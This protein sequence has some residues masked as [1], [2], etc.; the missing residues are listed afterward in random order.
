[1][2]LPL[3]SLVDATQDT[4]AHTRYN[5][6]EQQIRPWNVSDNTV[7]EVLHSLR[8]ED[9]VPPAHYQK[10]FMD[11]EIP[12]RDDAF[13]I[14][15]GHCMLAPKIDA[16]MANDLQ[17]Q[18]HERVLEIGTGSGYMAALLSRLCQD[19]TTLEIDPELAET[20]RENLA[21]AECHN[22]TVRVADGSQDSLSDGPFDAIVLS[23]S[24]AQIPEKLLAHLKDGGRLIAIV[25]DLPM[26]RVTIVRKQGGQLTTTTDVDNWPADVAGVQG[27]ELM[28]R[29][30]EHAERFKTQIVFDH[31]NAVDLSRRPFTLT[32]DSGQYTCDS[33]IIATGASAKYLGLPSEE[34]F[35]G[36]GVSACATCD[37]F[38]YREQEVCVVGG[39]NTAVEE[40]LYLANIASKVTLVHRRDRFRAEP[41][42]VDKLMERVAAGKIVL[43]TFF[44]LD[45]VLGDASGVTGIRIKSTED[46]HTEDIKLQGC[47]IAIGHAPNTEIFQGQITMENGY[48]ATQGG[49]KGFATQTSVPG[50]F[51]AGD[52]QDHVYRQ[53]IT[54]A[55]TG[56]MAALD[57]QRYLEQ[58]E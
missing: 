38:F 18:P 51:A 52:V 5:M 36:K 46:G 41:I 29:F 21:T 8:R 32:G 26:M 48:I 58:Q 7:L 9:F 57:A 14:E 40:A 28:Q 43:K 35:M 10:A 20:A 49:L 55:G 15:R 3:N 54:S 27:P 11:I 39:G 47:F 44:T 17:L 22:V 13:A 34:A 1:M 56:C 12:L 33:L 31:I 53:A 4:L 2:S 42:L 19:V 37:G 45:E 23:G 50:V 30:L 25:G 16:R 24:V 6:V